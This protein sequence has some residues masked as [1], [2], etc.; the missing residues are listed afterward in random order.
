L[1][2]PKQVVPWKVIHGIFKVCADLKLKLNKPENGIAGVLT[3]QC[4][5]K[6]EDM[7]NNEAGK[8]AKFQRRV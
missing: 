5:M 6:A 3:R 7:Q 2:V 8:A 1:V 4:V